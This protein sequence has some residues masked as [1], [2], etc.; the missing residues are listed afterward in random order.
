MIKMKLFFL[1][2]RRAVVGRAVIA[3]E[4]SSPAPALL[5]VREEIY[6]LMQLNFLEVAE[7]ERGNIYL[8][9]IELFRSCRG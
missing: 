5:K 4:R 6:I 9:A 1:K 2:R 3:R 7:G 8:I